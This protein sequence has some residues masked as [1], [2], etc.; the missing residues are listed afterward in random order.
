MGFGF[1]CGF[2][3]LLHME[4]VQVG[5]GRGEGRAGKGVDQEEKRCHAAPGGTVLSCWG[6]A[7]GVGNESGRG[8]GDGG[9]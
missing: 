7:G 2:L 8:D 9:S 6:S 1:R 4:I 3:G 5:R